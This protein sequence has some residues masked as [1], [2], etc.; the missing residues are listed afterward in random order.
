LGKIYFDGIGVTRSLK[1]AMRLTCLATTDEEFGPALNN[2]GT[3][4]REGEGKNLV[5]SLRYFERSVAVGY[6]PAQYNLGL[7]YYSS[8]Q[9]E[10]LVTQDYLHAFRL[11]MLAAGQGMVDAK[12]Y[13]GDMYNYGRGVTPNATQSMRW[14]REA[15]EGGDLFSQRYLGEV[16]EDQ[17]QQARGKQWGRRLGLG[18]YNPLGIVCSMFRSSVGGSTSTST[19]TSTSS[20]DVLKG[21]AMRY[22][23]M[24]AARGDSEAFVALERL[25]SKK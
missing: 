16:F 8:G 20:C 3:Y 18:Q 14:Y 19:S 2:M 24:A 7:M 9:D 17:Y 22:Y 25:E 10:A 6:A 5:E 21:E 23:H 1:E 11:F 13:L 4:Y 12:Y 15:A